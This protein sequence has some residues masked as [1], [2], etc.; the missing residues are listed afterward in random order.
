MFLVLRLGLQ[1]ELL[2]LHSIEKKML[3]FTQISYNSMISH[4]ACRL[5]YV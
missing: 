5:L 4:P 3:A 1:G 2:L